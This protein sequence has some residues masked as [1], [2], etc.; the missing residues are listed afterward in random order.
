MSHKPVTVNVLVNGIKLSTIDLSHAVSDNVI[1]LPASVLRGE[2]LK[3]RFE[4][5]TPK[6]DEPAAKPVAKTGRGGASS[7][8]AAPEVDNAASYGIKL[9]NMTLV[10]PT[11]VPVP[12]TTVAL[13]G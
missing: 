12:P 13:K 2:T 3:V 7:S 1:H 8:S 10:D 5:E 6:G 4:V 9:M 11:A